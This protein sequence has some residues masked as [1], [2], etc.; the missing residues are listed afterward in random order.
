MSANRL[1]AARD[2]DRS[3]A[4]FNLGRNMFSLS[5]NETRFRLYEKFS[6]RLHQNHDPN[7]FTLSMIENTSRGSF[8][9]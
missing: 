1:A 6:H 3:N 8:D 7:M 9:L 5:T 4:V 2:R